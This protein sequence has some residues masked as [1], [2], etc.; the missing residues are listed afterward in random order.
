MCARHQ[1]KRCIAGRW[2]SIHVSE[3]DILAGG[4]NV[5]SEAFRDVLLLKSKVQDAAV[6]PNTIDE[7]PIEDLMQYRRK[8]G[9]W[10]REIL[11]VLQDSLWWSIMP[12]VHES[13][14][15]LHHMLAW[16]QKRCDPDGPQHLAQLIDGKAHEF[17]REFE[18]IFRNDIPRKSAIMEAP[19]HLRARLLEFFVVLILHHAAA[20]KWRVLDHCTRFPNVAFK[21][22]TRPPQVSD[23]ERQRRCLNL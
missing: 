11:Q 18:N 9:R 20:F 7:I 2:G 10:S 8:L 23:P 17:M 5:I 22:A 4:R 16:L 6:P 14:A 21:L 13:R 3:N 15:P 19:S 12:L 1:P